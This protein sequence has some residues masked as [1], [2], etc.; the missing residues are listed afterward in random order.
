MDE[1]FYH[2]ARVGSN[3]VRL[4]VRSLKDTDG[5]EKTSELS[6]NGEGQTA[7]TKPRL[8]RGRRGNKVTKKTS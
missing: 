7:R 1:N 4:T 3:G 6:F 8:G 5:A 2:L